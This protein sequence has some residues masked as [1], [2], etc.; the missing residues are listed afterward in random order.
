MLL[1]RKYRTQHTEWVSHLA[2][3]FL[4]AVDFAMWLR[5]DTLTLSLAWY[6]CQAARVLG[7][8]IVRQEMSLRKAGTV[9][10]FRAGIAVAWLRYKTLR[11]SSPDSLVKV[12]VGHLY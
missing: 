1:H 9:L 2:F 8:V 11:L 3:V 7:S 5:E 4:V 10:S 12:L 6:V